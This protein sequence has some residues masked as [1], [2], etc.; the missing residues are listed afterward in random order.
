MATN[1]DTNSVEA[2]EAAPLKLD[3]TV[4][5]TPPKGN[6]IGFASKFRG[7]VFRMYSSSLRRW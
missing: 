6:L 2:V 4:R 1:K 3:V 5:P 7:A